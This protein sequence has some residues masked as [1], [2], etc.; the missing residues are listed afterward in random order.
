[1]TEETARKLQEAE[2]AEERA[3]S[4]ADAEKRACLQQVALNL[5]TKLDAF[6]KTVARDEPEVTKSLGADKLKQLR[7]DLAGAATSLGTDLQGAIDQIKWPSAGSQ[8]SSVTAGDIHSAL[9]NYMYGQRVDQLA[10]VFTRYGYSVRHG[11]HQNANTH[12]VPQQLY[13]EAWF[14]SVA[15][16]LQQ[17]G[18][19][20]RETERAR[21]MDN[22]S[23]VDTMWDS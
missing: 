8:Y 10:A 20:K 9:F 1:M 7:S 22:D 23:V 18:A 16:A 11:S 3:A 19:A 14:G 6:A 15:E 2:A 17:L 5:P 12:I 4:A 21:K 13:E